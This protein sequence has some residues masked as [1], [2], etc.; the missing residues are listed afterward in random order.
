MRKK[1]SFEV[2]LNEDQIPS[3]IHWNADPNQGAEAKAILISIFE[4]QSKE[5]LKMDLWTKDMQMMEMDRLFYYTMM[6]LSDTYFKS[7]K[8]QEL[9]SDMRNFAGYFGEKTGILKKE[10]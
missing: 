8:N 6:S 5:T 3:K 4:R 9:A 2:E 10:N 1:I 7:T